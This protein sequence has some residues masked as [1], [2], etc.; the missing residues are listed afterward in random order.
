MRA[1]GIPWVAGLGGSLC[2]GVLLADFPEPVSNAEGKTERES[3][4]PSDWASDAFTFVRVQY[5]SSGGYGESWYRYE[6]RDWQRW[7]TDYPRGEKNLLFRLNQLTSLRVQADPI[8]LRLTDS[9][10]FDYPFIFMSD[11]GWQQL[12]DGEVEAL[13]KYLRRGGFLW[14]DD[15]WG[16]AEWQNLV[17]NTQRLGPTWSWKPIPDDHEVLHCVYSL[18]ACPQVPAR[19]FFEQT[20]LSYDPPAVHRFPTGD[21]EGLRQVHFMGLFDS[22]GRLAAVATHNTDIADGWEREGEDHEFFTRFS[23]QAYALT[24]NIITYALTH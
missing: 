6:G 18:K 17:R 9:A 4:T 20:G 16:E 3:L 1:R 23:I 2:L 12:S 24:I 19:I 15:F 11:V 5:E 8:V 13:D 14:I 7:E 22:Q 21:R 10:L